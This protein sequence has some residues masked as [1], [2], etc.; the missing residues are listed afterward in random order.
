MGLALAALLMLP[1][2]ALAADDAPQNLSPLWIAG[3]V[4][5]AFGIIGAVFLDAV[6]RGN[7]LAEQQLSELKKDLKEHQGEVRFLRDESVRR[8]DM[9]RDLA[10]A[11]ADRQQIARQLADERARVDTRFAEL[12]GQI[13]KVDGRVSE[14]ADR[15]LEMMRQVNQVH[16]AQSQILDLLGAKGA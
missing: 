11:Q 1:D 5:L 9:S 3:T 12:T 8:S 14:M 6:R 2:A 13:S 7:K 16:V 10:T 15:Q 4:Q